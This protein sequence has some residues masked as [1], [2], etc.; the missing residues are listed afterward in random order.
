MPLLN[1]K[2]FKFKDRKGTE[3]TYLLGEIPAIPSQMIVLEYPLTA[4]P[5]LGDIE[6][7]KEVTLKL[8]SYV[9]IPRGE[10][11][12]PL[13]LTNEDLVNNH[14]P[15]LRTSMAVQRAIAAYNWD[16]FLPDD[17]SDFWGRLKTM[18][19]LWSQ[20][21]SMDSLQPSSPLE[22]PLSTN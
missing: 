14:I 7:H 13:Q 1:P 11:K 17:L 6:R 4:L 12:E 21:T 2:E 19:V 8:L 3:R 5:K 9:A 10:G 15:D 22:K 16:F 20:E 18:L